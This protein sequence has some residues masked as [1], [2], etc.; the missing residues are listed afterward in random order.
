METSWTGS[1][2]ARRE[3][4]QDRIR[5]LAYRLLGYYLSSW[6]PETYQL[7][8]R[9]SRK[10]R[11][12]AQLRRAI[13]PVAINLFNWGGK[14]RRYN[15]VKDKINSFVQRKNPVGVDLVWPVKSYISQLRVIQSVL[16]LGKCVPIGVYYQ[17]VHNNMF[18]SCLSALPNVWFACDGD[19]E[20]V[21]SQCS[22]WSL[23]LGV[24][25]RRLTPL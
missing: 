10:N 5:N 25:V 12:N 3:C 24:N 7:P 15:R 13:V 17:M 16:Q 8:C 2:C 6:V 23:S 19:H 1:R 4:I 20:P 21:I 11:D 9:L 18:G 22:S 14:R